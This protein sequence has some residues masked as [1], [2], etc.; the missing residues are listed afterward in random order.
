MKTNI[1]KQHMLRKRAH[2][3]TMQH[4]ILNKNV[5]AGF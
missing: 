4:S 2:Q 5:V 1:R 3:R